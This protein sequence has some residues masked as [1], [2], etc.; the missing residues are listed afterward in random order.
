MEVP[1]SRS[2]YGLSSQARKRKKSIRRYRLAA[3]SK[4]YMKASISKS[5]CYSK[6]RLI[7]HSFCMCCKVPVDI[8]SGKYTIV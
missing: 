3:K 5:S 1:H 2:L 6:Q 8:N 7:K 4:I